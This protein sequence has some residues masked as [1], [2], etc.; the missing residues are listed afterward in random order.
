MCNRWQL[1]IQ[2]KWGAPYQMEMASRHTEKWA[3]TSTEVQHSKLRNRIDKHFYSITMC[4]RCANIIIFLS[5]LFRSR[6]LCVD[7]GRMAR[8]A[9]YWGD[10]AIVIVARSFI[11]IVRFRV[12][13]FYLLPAR[14]MN[15]IL[16]GQ[17]SRTKINLFTEQK[18]P[19][20][21]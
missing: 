17:I 6:T 7:C 2:R 9:E 19:L 13:A 8:L 21:L 3:A 14:W 10:V 11:H 15:L 12:D 20:W 1:C 5:K 18:I 4:S 16:N